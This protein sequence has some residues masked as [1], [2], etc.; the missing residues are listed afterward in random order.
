MTT[1]RSLATP[2]SAPLTHLAEDAHE[3]RMVDVGKKRVTARSALA[4]AKVRFP[5]GVLRE[6][7]AHGGTKGPIEE[8]ARAAGLLAAK[9]T[10]ELIPMCHP[11][12]L[13]HAAIEFER[14][15]EDELE[16]R[17]RASCRGRTGV[18]MEALV[19]AAIAAL[20]VYDMTKSLSH[21]IEI[22]HVVLLEKR[23]G[24]SGTW[25][26]ERGARALRAVKRANSPRDAKDANSRR[27]GEH[28]SSSR[29]E[30]H[31]GTRAGSA[32]RGARRTPSKEKRRGR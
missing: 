2:R 8:V 20:T 25:R 31:A 32:Q 15:G 9:R 14:V 6:V 5:R 10:G 13:E 29:G 21:S 26:R 11:L 16:I 28:A 23:G 3:S 22:E 19:G 18:E 30:K 4:R 27:D 17:C 24:R 7:L 12:G 1:R